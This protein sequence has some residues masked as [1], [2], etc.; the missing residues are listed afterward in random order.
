M[1]LEPQVV[2]PQKFGNFKGVEPRK[3]RQ[4]ILDIQLLE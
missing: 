1:I 2:Q 4:E 3:I